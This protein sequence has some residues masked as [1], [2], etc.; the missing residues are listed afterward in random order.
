M[1]YYFTD[2]RSILFFKKII[3]KNQRE[4][5]VFEE[6]LPLFHFP[7]YSLGRGHFGIF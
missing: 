1:E 5:L 4:I 2:A 6:M 7:S 3:I